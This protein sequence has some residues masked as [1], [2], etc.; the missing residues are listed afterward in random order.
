MDGPK[1]GDQGYLAQLQLRLR[2]ALGDF[3]GAIRIL[4]EVPPQ[5][6]TVLHTAVAEDPAA[7]ERGLVWLV[8]HF[9]QPS[10]VVPA[11]G[12]LAP[13][14]DALIGTRARQLD[15]FGDA[16]AEAVR[17][18]REERGERWSDEDAGAWRDAWRFAV[19][20]LRQGA[21]LHQGETPYWTGTVVAH[22][23]RRDDVAVLTVMTDLP[24]P[25]RAGQRA[26]VECHQVPGAWRACWIGD[27]P[28]EDHHIEIHVQALPGDRATGCLVRDG[29]VGDPI[30]LHRAEGDFKIEE[31]RPG[32]V[33]I[34]AEDVHVTPV[35]ALL[36]ELALRGDER[37]VHLFWGVSTRD[38]LYDLESLREHAARCAHA[39]VHAVVAR[40]PAH[41]Y[42]S[43]SLPQVVV[44][45]GE[46]T[47]H[48]VYLS[49]SGL[50]VGVMRN[51]LLQRNV[52]PRR[53]HT[54]TLEPISAP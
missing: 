12:R 43:G 5:M 13:A 3:H 38:D 24:Y 42:V 41:P 37:V 21:Q 51:M 34:V 23:R 26:I 54:V 39:F 9:D 22:D 52:D 19:G 14:L 49:G 29:G 18:A 50:A 44:D 46:W 10:A 53:I 8:E 11:L 47:S 33:L 16:L 6:R 1:Q 27:P 45:F 40:G 25:F 31:G 7:A 2:A 17:E 36:S 35:K 4:A 28:A 15:L 48:D 20:W 30:R 32:S